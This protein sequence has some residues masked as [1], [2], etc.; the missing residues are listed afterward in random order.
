[1]AKALWAFLAEN[2]DLS[3]EWSYEFV[4]T[5]WLDNKKHL[6]TNVIFAVALWCLWEYRN[7]LCFQGAVWSGMKEL[8]LWIT[9]SLR[10]WKPLLVEA[11]G[12]KLDRMV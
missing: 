3:S 11:D 2:I 1:V 8:V 9:K 5:F 7:K 6:L 10:R 12:E 4:A